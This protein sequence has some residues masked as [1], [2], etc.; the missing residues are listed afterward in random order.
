MRLKLPAWMVLAAIFALAASVVLSQPLNNASGLTVDFSRIDS[1][2]RT[3]PKLA[4]PAEVAARLA[5]AARTDWE[6]A[7]AVYDWVC[8]NIVY[9]TDAYFGGIHGTVSAE[10]TFASGKSVCQGYSELS[11]DLATMAGIRS[12]LIEGYSKGYSY[13]PGRPTEKNHAWNAFMIDGSWYLMDTTWGSGA[14]DDDRR[15]KPELSYAWFAMDPTLFLYTHFSE[16]P[17]APLK[18]PGFT[19]ADFDRLPHVPTYVFEDMYGAGVGAA[20]QRRFA[21]ELG[22]D[23]E[24]QRWAL[25]ELKKAGFLDEEVLAVLK[26]APDQQFVYEVL[27]LGRY[28]FP[29]AALSDYLQ[30]GAAPSIYEIKGDLNVIDVPLSPVLGLG[31]TYRFRVMSKAAYAVAVICGK[32]WTMLRRDGSVF[33]GE[34]KVTGAP[35]KLALRFEESASA[36]YA[37][38][39]AYEAK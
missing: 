5:K 30:R 18:R 23:L 1:Y 36:S 8:L 25:T 15:F 33:Y 24:T 16:D 39:L 7:R 35:V 26:T 32:D 17:S 3:M 13:V 4:S 10:S 14:I 22:P 20:A 38:A 29:K 21:S 34:V 27:E 12:V 31:K 11:Q 28:G 6:R 37:T 2:V 19:K 9:D